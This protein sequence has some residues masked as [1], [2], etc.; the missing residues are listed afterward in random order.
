MQPGVNDMQAR[1]DYACVA[2]GTLF[3]G[4]SDMEVV[5]PQEARRVAANIVARTTGRLIL[6]RPHRRV[7]T[8]P[9]R[10]VAVA[11]S[12]LACSGGPIPNWCPGLSSQTTPG[13]F[14]N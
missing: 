4:D 1:I 8:I 10:E 2:V 6:T 9:P 3:A 7:F 5:L 11:I 14:R 13:N 12:L